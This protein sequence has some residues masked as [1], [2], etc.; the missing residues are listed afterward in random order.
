MYVVELDRPWEEAPFESPFDLQ[1]FTIT[2]VDEIEK[3]RKLCRFV[4]IDP[5]L[6]VGATRYLSDEHNLSALDSLVKKTA[7]VMPLEEFY[8]EQATVKEELDRAQ[9][10][11]SDTRE[12]YDKVIQDLQAGT[13]A[14]MQAVKKTV[15]SLVQSVLRNPAA[16]AWLVRL[17]HRD[18]SSY[19]HAISVCVMALTLGRFL[20][21]PKE[22]LQTL[23][24]ATLLQDL[25]KVKLPTDL[26]SKKEELSKT[27]REL[28][29]KHVDISVL[30]VREMEDI[31]KDVV[32]IV[33]SHHERYDGSGYPRKFSR[34]QINTLSV[35]AGL[36]DTYEAITADRPHR[37]AKTSFQALMELYE[38]RD[39]GFPGGLVEQF[40]QC[41]GIFPVGSFVQ[42][43]SD[44]VGV[45]VSRNRVHQLKPRV[46][47]LIDSNGQKLSEPQTVDL[48]EQHLPSSE[49]QRSIKKIVD[50]KEY[51]LDP[52][53]FFF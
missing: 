6:G 43:N 4:Y 5:D 39:M 18:E 36:I 13:V 16:A 44:E 12:V 2:H 34:T 25:G 1:G 10:I 33:S 45:I 24:V 52:A 49:V 14:D 32:D 50:A 47:I 7:H 28:I 15:D 3:I 19:S 35:I 17:K 21:L 40:I 9:E 41:V 29:K 27:E 26:L 22:E 46:M 48:A 23:G 51:D 37:P 11:M 38:Q 31:P 53:Q 42:L 8:P 20:G 30:L